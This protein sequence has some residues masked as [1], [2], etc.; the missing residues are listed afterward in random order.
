MGRRNNTKEVVEMS[1]IDVKDMI[2]TDVD[3]QAE[4]TKQGLSVS[5]IIGDEEIEHTSTYEDMAIDMVGD[6]EK[7]DNE[8]LKKI[9]KGFDYMSKFIKESIGKDG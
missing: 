9:A 4:F 1:V 8:T 3:L 6:S 2:E 5:V 7:Y